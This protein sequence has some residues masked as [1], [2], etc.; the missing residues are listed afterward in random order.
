[1]NNFTK[2]VKCSYFYM[3]F[4][5]KPWIKREVYWTLITQ[6]V[7]TCSKLTTETLEQGVKYVHLCHWRRS[8]V[9]VVN[10]EHILHLVLAILLL[11]LSN[12]FVITLYLVST[13]SFRH[14]GLCHMH[15]WTAAISTIMNYSN[16]QNIP[17]YF[18]STFSFKTTLNKIIWDFWKSK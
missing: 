11:T 10:F 18:Y 9:F 1:M 5:W 4:L 14:L 17:T 12:N 7:F 16:F 6:P 15:F 3:Y 2:L 13:Q 8:G